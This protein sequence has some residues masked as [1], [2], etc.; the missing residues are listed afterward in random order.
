MRC[1]IPEYVICTYCTYM[2]ICYVF[3][4]T[5]KIFVYYGKVFFCNVRRALVLRM[6]VRLLI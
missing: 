4:V 1:N 6:L 3:Y 2:F 5:L